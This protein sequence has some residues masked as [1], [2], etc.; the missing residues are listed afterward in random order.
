MPLPGWRGAYIADWLG[1]H[2]RAKIHFSAY[3]ESQ[4]TSPPS[5]PSVPNPKVNL[6]RETEEKGTAL[7][8]SGYIARRPGEQSHPHHY[9]MNQ[10]FVDQLLR[11]FLWTGDTAYLREIWPLLERHFA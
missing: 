1:W 11:H 6:A 9:D 8:T 10:V 7:F 3:K 4:Y 2:D 5:G